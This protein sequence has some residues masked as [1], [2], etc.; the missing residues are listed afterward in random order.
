MAWD[1]LRR[2]QPQQWITHRFPLEQAGEAYRLL[3]ESPGEAI[4]VV[5][6]YR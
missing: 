4:Q 3:D 6:E 1:A 5:F 2:I